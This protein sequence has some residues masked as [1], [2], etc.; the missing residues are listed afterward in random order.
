MQRLLI[1]LILLLSTGGLMSQ[2]KTFPAKGNK[3]VHL[4]FDQ[5]SITITGTNEAN[6][7][8]ETSNYEEPPARAKGLKPLYNNATDNTGIG[9]MLEEDNGVMTI[10]QAQS[11]S[12]DYTIKMPNNMNVKFE[13]TTWMGNSALTISGI[14]GEIEA[15][16]KNS[17]IIL[18]DVS[19]PITAGTT[20]GDIEVIFSSLSQKGPTTITNISGYIDVTMAANAKANLVLKNI[21]GEIY[22]N[23]KLQPKGKDGLQQVGGNRHIEAALNSGGVEL[24]LKNISGDIFLRKQ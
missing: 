11:K 4:I 9:L 15:E 8:V 21:S 16:T 13:E 14:S 12:G 3:T 19:G 10:R 17:A 20:S 2:T 5:A 23:L 6:L 1:L 24:M 18:K 22:S 7:V